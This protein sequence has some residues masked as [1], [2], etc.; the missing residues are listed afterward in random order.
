MKN[1][2]VLIFEPSLFNLYKKEGLQ[3]YFQFFKKKIDDFLKISKL[4]LFIAIQENKRDFIKEFF[5]D[6]NIIVYDGHFKSFL[7]S[8]NEILQNNSLKNENNFTL[9]LSSSYPLFSFSKNIFLIED[10]EKYLVDY[11]YGE[12]FPEG[13]VGEV[14][15][16]SIIDEIIKLSNEKETYRQNIIFDILLKNISLFDIDLLEGFDYYLPYRVSLSLSDF[17]SIPLIYN[18]LKSNIDQFETVENKKTDKNVKLESI[19]NLSFFKEEINDNPKYIEWEKIEGKLKILENLYT[20]PKT[21]IIEL[22]SKCNFSCIHCP[23]PKG[24][25]RDSEFLNKEKLFS[26]INSNSLY[27]NDAKFIIGGFGEPFMHKDFYQ[28]INFLCKNNKV[29][30]ETN[31]SFLNTDFFDNFENPDNIFLII[32]IDAINE[33]TYKKLGKKMILPILLKTTMTLLEKYPDNVYVSYLRTIHN[34][35]EIET[36]Y[37]NFQ[38]FEKNIIFR[39][40]NSYSLQLENLEVADLTPVERFPCYHLRRELFILSDGK[41]S[42]CYSD[43][44]GELLNLTIDDNFEQIINSYRKYFEMHCNKSYNPL[45]EKCNEF[46]TYFF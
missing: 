29:Y 26:F 11:Y 42:L 25:K 34:D 1:N 46:Y 5:P 31:G 17:T 41:I 27:F 37:S 4:N 18:I 9:L 3:N 6:E 21:F 24:L 12:N 10:A 44:N 38:K 40:Y 36:F 32:S 39:K 19:S 30:I 33:I 28:I 22:S 35:D 23:Y 43:F 13:I 45:C 8:Y 20:F 14:F 7:I 2:L 15:K 16:N